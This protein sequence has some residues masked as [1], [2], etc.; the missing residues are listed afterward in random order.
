M[1]NFLDPKMVS[2]L[3]T[4][5][6]DKVRPTV[7]LKLIATSDIG[8]FAAIALQN[9]S[10]YLEQTLSIAGDSL[11]Y[12]EIDAVFRAVQG[13]PLPTTYSLVGTV[14]NLLIKD[15]RTMYVWPWVQLKRQT[16]VEFVR[17]VAFFDQVGYSA[18]VEQ[19]RKI[20][21]E[22]KTLKQYLEANQ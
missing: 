6:R 20:Y 10:V 12:G 8:E 13:K 9:P 16:N 14:V 15:L 21:P 11:T 22:L 19:S 17:R 4:L 3:G 7:P 18:N 1:D 2:V 5:L